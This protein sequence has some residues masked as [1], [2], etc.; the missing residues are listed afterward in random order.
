MQAPEPF[1]GLPCPDSP[2]FDLDPMGKGERMTS[3]A[4]LD[5]TPD[6]IAELAQ[7]VEARIDSIADTMMKRYRERIDS[8]RDAPPDV[9]ADAREWAR[10]SIAI[11]VGIIAG[12][13]DVED[14]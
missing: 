6:V 8:Y 12:S 14:F 2:H 13:L 10:A 11:S 5:T 3:S 1:S 7:S 4:R 9:I